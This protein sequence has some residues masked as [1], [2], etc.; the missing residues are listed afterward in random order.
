M[1][2]N[3]AL[4]MWRIPSGGG[5][6]VPGVWGE[7][8]SPLPI[9]GFGIDEGPLAITPLAIGKGE[10]HVIEGTEGGIGPALRGKVS[11]R[12]G[13]Q[14]PEAPPGGKPQGTQRRRGV[15]GKGSGWGAEGGLGPN[16]CVTS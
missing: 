4:L 15:G 12:R 16:H 5:S 11:R 8:S 10:S 1:K 6:E 9:I 2:P 3:S 13:R 7:K 14:D